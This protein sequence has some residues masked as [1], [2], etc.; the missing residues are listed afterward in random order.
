MRFD[1]FFKTFSLPVFSAAQSGREAIQLARWV[2]AGR[3]VRLKRG[4]YRFTDREVDE[5]SL[6]GY[7]Y[8]PSYISLE[9]ALN[10]QGIIPDVSAAVTSISPTTTK[11]IKTS[12]GNY[13]YAKIQPRLFWGWQIISDNHQVPYKI[14]LPEKALLDWVYLR[15]I[16]NL[17]SHRINRENLNKSRLIK[18]TRQFPGWVRKVVD[19][20]LNR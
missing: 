3:L 12:R 11:M 8:S 15:K 17:S 5:F 9:T 13:Y 19:E 14:A 20:Q 2:K 1:K 4:V 18:F 6:A 7:L 10:N 16:R